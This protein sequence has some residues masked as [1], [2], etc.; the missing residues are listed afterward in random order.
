LRFTVVRMFF[1][2][3]N[4]RFTLVRMFFGRYRVCSW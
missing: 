2:L 4:T 1:T 3:E